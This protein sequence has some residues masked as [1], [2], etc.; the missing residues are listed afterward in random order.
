MNKALWEG[1]TSRVMAECDRPYR[2][3]MD[4]SIFDCFIDGGAE[5]GNWFGES[6]QSA[7]NSRTT[8]DEE[9][10]GGR[11]FVGLRIRAVDPGNFS[12]KLIEAIACLPRLSLR[13]STIHPLYLP[14]DA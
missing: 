14:L 11:R 6:R 4:D 3:S 9:Q 1:H 10:G 8:T 5:F 12:W 2:E 13:P 7:A